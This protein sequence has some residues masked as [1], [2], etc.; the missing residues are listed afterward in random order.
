MFGLCTPPPPL[1]LPVTPLA[2]RCRHIPGTSDCAQQRAGSGGV[3]HLPAGL[4]PLA[5]GERERGCFRY[6]GLDSL[7]YPRFLIRGPF[8]DSW[9][10]GYSSSKFLPSCFQTAGKEV[11]EYTEEEECD[12]GKCQ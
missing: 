1:A 11:N 2:E 10:R 12:W 8:T 9:Q 7:L 6:R 5:R 3:T 4:T